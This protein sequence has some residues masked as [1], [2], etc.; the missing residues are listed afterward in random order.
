ME[1]TQRQVI[2]LCLSM[3]GSKEVG[4]S[5]KKKEEKEG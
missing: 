1:G 2:V 4:K 3:C 5:W